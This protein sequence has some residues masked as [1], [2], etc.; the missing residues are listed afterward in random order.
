MSPCPVL[1]SSRT[2][3]PTPSSAWSTAQPSPRPAAS[4]LHLTSRWAS[5]APPS[6]TG[7]FVLLTTRATCLEVQ[8]CASGAPA[9][10]TTSTPTRSPYRSAMTCTTEEC[11][12]AC[13][14]A[15]RRLETSR[16]PST[17]PA[18]HFT[19]VSPFIHFTAC[20]NYLTVII[21]FTKTLIVDIS[22]YLIA[23]IIIDC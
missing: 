7:M 10:S 4:L 12:T 16:M 14:T 3:E 17:V 23:V 18:S 19:L 13:W 1:H 20:P 2:T 8:S 9:P 11:W 22:H 6:Q 21:S 15:L 5:P